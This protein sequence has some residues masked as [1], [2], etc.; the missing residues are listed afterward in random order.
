MSGI[1]DSHNLRK[2]NEIPIHRFDVGEGKTPLISL[3]VD[4]Q[5]ILIKDENAI[6]QDH[7]KIAV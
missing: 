7:S 1:W 4:E 5:R 3:K 2:Y 6:Q